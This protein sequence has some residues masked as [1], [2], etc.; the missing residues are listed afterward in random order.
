MV[1]RCEIWNIIYNVIGLEDNILELD[2]FIE[3]R[4]KWLVDFLED[5]LRMFFVY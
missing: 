4:W 2:L 5:S 3:K 1:I